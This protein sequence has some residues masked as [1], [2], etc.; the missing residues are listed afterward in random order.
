M[1]KIKNLATHRVTKFAAVGVVNTGIDFLILNILRLV[2]HT[3]SDNKL[4]LIG[5]NIVSATCVA[6]ISFYLN[7]SF[8]FQKSDTH[9]RKLWLFVGI[10]ITGIFVWQSLAIYAALPL[11]RP[12]SRALH[13]ALSAGSGALL[14]KF[15]EDFY[16]ANIS[17]LIATV[18]SMIWNYQMY[19]RYV[20]TDKL[21]A[22]EASAE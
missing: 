17:K 10:S 21:I 2:T 1:T 7:R 4:G 20:F 19:K 16:R 5:L 14:P 22:L 18:V 8:V 11:V 6:I 9:H 3:S 12:L 13:S 15:T